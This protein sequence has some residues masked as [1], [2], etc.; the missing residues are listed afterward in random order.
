MRSTSKNIE[1]PPEMFS[2]MELRLVRT[3]VAKT[4]KNLESRL[5][6]LDPESDDAV[7]ATNDLMLYKTILEKINETSG[8]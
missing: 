2:V 7:E 4:M 3:S 6:I 5:K 8:V 1:K